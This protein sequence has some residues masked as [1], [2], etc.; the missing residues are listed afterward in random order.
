MPTYS[1]QLGD[2]ILV[3][4]FLLF[5]VKTGIM[6][7]VLNMVIT[8]IL[9]MSPVGFITSPYNLIALGTMLLGVYFSSKIISYPKFQYSANRAARP[10]IIFTTLAVLTRTLLMLLFDYTLYGFLLSLLSGLSIAASYSIVIAAMPGIILYNITVPLYAIPTSYLIAK[11][12]TTYLKIENTLVLANQKN[13][14]LA[15]K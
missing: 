4:A 14:V 3:I 11:K 1:Y 6:T 5:G 2:I 15:I 10:V 9:Y 13:H 12:V 7:A 8:M